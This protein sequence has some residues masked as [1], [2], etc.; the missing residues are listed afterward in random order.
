MGL[1]RY[2][3][4]FNYHYKKK[5]INKALRA[6]FLRWLGIDEQIVAL[7]YFLNELHKPSSI[8]HT[9]DSDLRKLQECDTTLLAIFHKFCVDNK[10]TYWLDYG[11]L[12]GAVR[13]KGFIPWDDDMDVAMPREDYQKF[14]K[15]GME[16]LTPLGLCIEEGA[17]GQRIGLSYKHNETGVWLDIFPVDRKENCMEIEDIMPNISKGFNAFRKIYKPSKNKDAMYYMSKRNELI[18]EKIPQGE[19][20]IMY[21]GPEYH[22]LKI[23]VHYEEEII[24][25]LTAVF[26]GREF[27]VPAKPIEY[28]M[29]IYGEHFME[30]PKDGVLHHGESSN[31][32]PLSKWAMISNTDMQEINV[33]LNEI[34]NQI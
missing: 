10:L 17:V 15:L 31:R 29:R 24:P 25:R 34:L 19:N 5:G 8:V 6:V 4:T 27:Y 12:L 32:A 2:Y 7:Q 3:K 20:I 16:K 14:M 11:T 18:N 23:Y 1:K 22:S 30:F 33:K 26:E 9:S 21:H 28:L 13:H